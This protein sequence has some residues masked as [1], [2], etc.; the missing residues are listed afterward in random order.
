MEFGGLRDSFQLQTPL[1]SLHKERGSSLVE[2][3]LTLPMLLLLLFGV[4]DLGRAVY[5]QNVITNAAREGA[6][7]GAIAPGDSQAIQT[8]TETAIVGLD[9]SAVTVTV[10]QTSNTIRVTVTYQF[11]SITPLVGQF[12]GAGGAISLEGVSTMNIESLQ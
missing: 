6:R 3:A 4:L 9:M 5:A 2:M 7:F 10:T 11:N 12:L 1:T 8:Q